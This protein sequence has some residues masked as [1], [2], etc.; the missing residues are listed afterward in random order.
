MINNVDKPSDVKSN[1]LFSSNFVDLLD[2]F[3]SAPATGPG[4]FLARHSKVSH[5]FRFLPSDLFNYV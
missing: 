2:S 1:A 4:P 5:S 3:P